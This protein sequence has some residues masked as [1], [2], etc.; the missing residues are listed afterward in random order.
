V[1]G[2]QF[3]GD[4]ED[5]LAVWG[6]VAAIPGRRPL[7]RRVAGGPTFPCARAN[8]VVIER[9]EVAP[10]VAWVYGLSRTVYYTDQLVCNFRLVSPGSV[11]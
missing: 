7:I 10:V 4:V 5:G 3:G 1:A 8:P 9:I 11:S 2:E 6:A